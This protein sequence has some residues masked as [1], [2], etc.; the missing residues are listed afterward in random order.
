MNTEE[1]ARAYDEALER[2]KQVLSNNCTEVEKLCFECI[3]PEL[4]ESED[5][6]IRKEII[7][8]I[9][10]KANGVSEEQEHAWVAY[11]EKQ[12]DSKVV[13]FDH[14]REQGQSEVDLEKEIDEYFKDWVQDDADSI[15]N[16]GVIT[17][18]YQYATIFDCRRIAR[19]FYEL[20]R[21]RK[22][23]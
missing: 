17:D 1:K 21:T 16:G 11:L 6:S 19:H 2:A 5:E 7:H 4:A 18:K 13:K 14:D 23:E 8:Y 15:S 20:G 10:Y 9:L 22:K 12:K 3:F